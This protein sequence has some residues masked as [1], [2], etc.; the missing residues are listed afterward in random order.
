MDQLRAGKTPPAPA[1][2]PVVICGDFNSMPD[3]PAIQFLRQYFDSAYVAIHGEEPEYTCPTPLPYSTKTKLRIADQKILGQIPATDT[4]WR[5]TLDYIFVDP[6][7]QTQ[8]C[9]L[10]LNQPAKHNDDI[11]PS[12]HFGLI[13]Q[14]KVL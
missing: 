11:Y 10:V 8:A 6:R 7:L 3:S 12:D 13:A 5:G 1:E 4:A 9:D 2:I 14:I